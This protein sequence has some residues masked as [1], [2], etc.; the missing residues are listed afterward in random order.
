MPSFFYSNNKGLFISANYQMVWYT[1]DSSGGSF[2]SNQYDIGVDKGPGYLDIR[3]RITVGGS[4]PLPW[5]FSASLFLIANSSPPFNIVLGQDLNGDGVFNDRPAFATDL[6]RPSVV[7]T[8]WGT[9]DTDPL[10]T[11]RIIPYDYGRAPA[12]LVRL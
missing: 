1:M 10:P 12:G 8:K 6:T 9:F 11:Q 4:V 2:P 3:H 5:H 7:T